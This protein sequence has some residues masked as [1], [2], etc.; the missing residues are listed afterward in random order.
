M[1][2]THEMDNSPEMKQKLIANPFTCPFKDCGK[3]CK[4][5]TAL[6]VHSLWGH[7]SWRGYCTTNTT[8]KKN[9]LSEKMLFTC[10]DAVVVCVS[11]RLVKKGKEG[12][13][14]K[15][16]D[17]KAIMRNIRCTNCGGEYRDYQE[18][19]TEFVIAYEWLRDNGY[20]I[21]YINT[22]RVKGL[23]EAYKSILTD[24][25]Y[26]Y[27][28]ESANK[29]LG[30]TDDQSKK[31]RYWARHTIH[32]DWKFSNE[33][34]FIT[35]EIMGYDDIDY[36]INHNNQF[37]VVLRILAKQMTDAYKE[38][39]YEYGWKKTPEWMN[40]PGP[41]NRYG[42]YKSDYYF[43]VADEKYCDCGFCNA[44][45]YDSDYYQKSEVLDE[46]GINGTRLNDDW[47]ELDE[48]HRE[49]VKGLNEFINKH[50]RLR[51]N[52]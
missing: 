26:K 13:F 4:D 24:R 6:N 21:Q 23:Y 39:I 33:I 35:N 50:E 28:V 20:S 27:R 31:A 17:T 12:Y 30:L 36:I 18:P 42:K 8:S 43:T 34:Q 32:Q 5:E 47:H 19:G 49:I 52:G 7:G 22:A 38:T 41:E 25:K 51:V 46:W 45:A 40:E 1:S 44:L 29:K 48:H 2:Q 10:Q 9:G 3:V 14:C 15:D 37:V 11:S 16:C